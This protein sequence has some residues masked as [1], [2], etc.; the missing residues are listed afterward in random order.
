ML[1]YAAVTSQ[2]SSNAWH[3][4]VSYKIYG[5]VLKEPMPSFRETE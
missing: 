4:I 1:G 5:L 2:E 3:R